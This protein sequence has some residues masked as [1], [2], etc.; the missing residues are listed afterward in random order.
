M[1]VASSRVTF[2]VAIVTSACLSRWKA[3]SQP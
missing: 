2:S 1:R 3:I